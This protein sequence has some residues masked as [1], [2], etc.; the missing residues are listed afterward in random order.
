[1]GTTT[2]PNP[3]TMVQWEAIGLGLCFPA[4]AVMFIA[5]VCGSM[6]LGCGPS[7]LKGPR[8]VA[9]NAT[10]FFACAL[11][12][13]VPFWTCWAWFELYPSSVAAADPNRGLSRTGCTTWVPNRTVDCTKEN[14][15]SC[16]P[17]CDACDVAVQP[18]AAK[19]I[20]W[21]H[22]FAWSSFIFALVLLTIWCAPVLMIV[23]ILF[24]GG[25]GGDCKCLAGEIGPWFLVAIHVFLVVTYLTSFAVCFSGSVEASLAGLHAITTTQACSL[26]PVPQQHVRR[27]H[28]AVGPFAYVTSSGAV[29]TAA[30]LLVALAAAA[31]VVVGVCRAFRHNNDDANATTGELPMYTNTVAV[32]CG[33]VED[34]HQFSM[35]GNPL[36][37]Q[38]V[39]MAQPIA[40]GSPTESEKG[41]TI[42]VDF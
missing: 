24:G 42:M 29:V 12:M 3:P 38:P 19:L 17:E 32:G 22:V 36:K 11:V 26:P 8:R 20:L 33:Q 7:E 18:S 27:F 30:A 1:M 31:V 16:G 28:D 6:A 34:I 13:L 23:A 15:V 39:I 14:T 35:L 5:V 41:Q 2:G 9:K 25:G 10:V 37:V 21:C 40:G 4:A